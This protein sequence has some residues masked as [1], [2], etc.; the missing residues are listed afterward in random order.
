MNRHSKFYLQRVIRQVVYTS[1]KLSGKQVIVLSQ[2]ETKDC[3]LNL[4]VLIGCVMTK[5]QTQTRNIKV[6]R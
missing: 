3:K 6:L 2:L 4:S 1:W 5:T